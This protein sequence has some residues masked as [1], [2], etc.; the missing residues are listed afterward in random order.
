MAV[1]SLKIVS[2]FYGIDDFLPITVYCPGAGA[3]D[4]LVLVFSHKLDLTSLDAE[5]FEI[6]TKNGINYIPDCATLTPAGENNEARTVLLVGQFG[7]ASVNEPVKVRIVDNLLTRASTQSEFATCS[8]VQN[9]KGLSIDTVIPLSAGPVISYALLLDSNEMQL[10]LP[11]SPGFPGNNIGGG[12][13]IGTKQVVQVIWSGGITPSNSGTLESDLA[14][15]YT[16]WVDSAGIIIPKI[17]ALIADINDRDNYHDVC[18]NTLFKPV[19]ITFA[20]GFVNDPNNDSNPVT[21]KELTYCNK[22]TDLPTLYSNIIQV[23]AYPNPAKETINIDFPIKDTYN[24]YVYDYFGKIILETTC[25]GQ[26]KIDTKD[27]V[28]GF[29]IVVA[30]Q[31]GI[32]YITRVFINN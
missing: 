17:P 18:L 32:T 9:A 12:C 7:S 19:K 30:T 23:K 14:Q 3:V 27:F 6:T 13:P 8:P 22:S 21:E 10:G 26:L 11:P 25:K 24:I 20:Q 4:G 2:A 15:Y 5:D 1:D 31:D 29:H 16:V 28:N